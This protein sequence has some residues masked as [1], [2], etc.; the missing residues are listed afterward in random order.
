MQSF[1][2]FSLWVSTLYHNSPELAID[3]PDISMS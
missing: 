3:K 2:T 1:K